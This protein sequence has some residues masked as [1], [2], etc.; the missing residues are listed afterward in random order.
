MLADNA[1][2]KYPTKHDVVLQVAD[3]APYEDLVSVMDQFLARD[4]DQLVVMGAEL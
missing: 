2:M 3:D 1:R 4:F